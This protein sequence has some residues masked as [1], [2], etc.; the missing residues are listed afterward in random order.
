MQRVEPTEKGR[1]DMQ[2]LAAAQ[3]PP[4][5]LE[6]RYH[7]TS[8]ATLYA[9]ATVNHE[10]VRRATYEPSSK[11]GEQLRRDYLTSL[12]NHNLI[13]P[14][15]EEIDWSG[16]GQHVVYQR[17]DKVFLEHISYLGSGA[18]GTVDKVLC[19]RVALARK[20]TLMRRN[21]IRVERVMEEVLHLQKIRRF[22]II[23]LVGSYLQNHDLSILMY[24]V[25]ECNLQEFL[26][27]TPELPNSY[28][29]R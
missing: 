16:R 26:Q 20:T 21:N 17:E 5:N 8:I 28:S 11:K 29:L 1:S 22:H 13:M 15:T 23:Q 25:A 19:R 6:V 18:Y 14:T 12:D 27:D 2:S 7:D 3:K 9:T 4:K 24:P 10:E